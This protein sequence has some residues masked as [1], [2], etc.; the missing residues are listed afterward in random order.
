MSS[1]DGTELRRDDGEHVDRLLEPIAELYGE[2]YAEPPYNGGPLF[3]RERF[4]ERTTRQKSNDGF[5][6]VS[7]YTGPELQGFAFGFPFAAGG[8]WRGITTPQ[9]SAEILQA[10]KFAVIELV[11]R[12]TQRGHGLGRALMTALLGGRTEPYA[13]LLAKPDAPARTIY[14]RWGWQQVATVQPTDDAPRLAAL[15]LPLPALKPGANGN[16][17]PDPRR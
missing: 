9:P 2:V 10:L 4:L 17:P 16:L 7:A 5:T 3:T 1:H 8:W 11:V 6:L 13:T 12:K 15:I 14:Q